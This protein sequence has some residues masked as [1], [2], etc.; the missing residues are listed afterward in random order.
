[1][2]DFDAFEPADLPPG[3][4]CFQYVADGVRGAAAGGRAARR[5]RRAGGLHH[6]V[7]DLDTFWTD[8]LGGTVRSS[9]LVLSQPDQ[10]QA[11]KQRLYG[12]A[13]GRRRSGE[14]YEV[15]CAAKLGAATR[16]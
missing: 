14:G 4:A 12:E 11:S 6:C 5:C 10:V 9:A 15:P 13:L 16:S 1:M 8:L 3:P 2:A 7:E